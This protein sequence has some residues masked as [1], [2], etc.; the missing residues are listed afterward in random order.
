[1]KEKFYFQFVFYNKLKICW[2]LNLNSTQ[3]KKIK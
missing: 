1:M 2:L 3:I